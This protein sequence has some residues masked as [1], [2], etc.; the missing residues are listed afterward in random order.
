MS[1]LQFKPNSFDAAILIDT[2]YF[3]D[4]FQAFLDKLLDIL[5]PGGQIGLFSDEGRG[6]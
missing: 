1:N 5:T 3:I 2:H 6:R 4:D